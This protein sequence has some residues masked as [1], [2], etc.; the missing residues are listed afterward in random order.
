MASS[1]KKIKKREDIRVCEV[2]DCHHLIL[3]FSFPKDTGLFNSWR[4]FVRQN[5]VR[6]MN[7]SSHLYNNSNQTKE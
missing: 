1:A 3:C 7:Y 2:A 5:Q 4:R 6:K